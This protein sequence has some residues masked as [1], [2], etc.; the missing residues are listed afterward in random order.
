M[1]EW[2][3]HVLFLMVM[4][5]GVLGAILPVLPGAPITFGT[6]I[7]AKILQ[8][9]DLN[10]WLIVIFGGLTLLG[11]LLDYL[12]P[13]VA[14]KKMGG[15]KYGI[16]GMILGLIIGIIFAP[17]GFVSIIISPF[18]GALI[19]ELIY[20]TKNHKRAF[21]AAL[22]SVVGYA[23]TSS[24]GFLLSLSMFAVYLFYDVLN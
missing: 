11:V 6:L 20:D 17:F 4:F 10:W 13:I 2:V 14:T 7:T 21:T 22:G 5:V 1:D 24:Y 18:L 8:F 19:G 12:I 16:V 23:L 15:S 9:S 3:I